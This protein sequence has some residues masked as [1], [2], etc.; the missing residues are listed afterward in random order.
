MQTDQL[1]RRRIS[2]TSSS[3]DYQED[4]RIDDQNLSADT[5]KSGFLHK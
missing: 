1:V 5:P 4:H 3:R 2:S